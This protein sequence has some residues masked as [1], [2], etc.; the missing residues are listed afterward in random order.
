MK[1]NN[2]N[3]NTVL[4]IGQ[5]VKVP[6]YHV[7]VKATPGSQY[8]ELLDWWTEAQFVLKYDLPFTVTD[9][10]TG[11]SFQAVRSFG[12][13]HADCE[14]LTT[15]DT[16]AITNLWN[17]YHSSYWTARP[18]II[19][20]NGRKLA[21]S[22]TAAFHAGIDNAPNG[23]YVNNRSGGYG[24]GQNFDAIKGNGA[25]G[26]FDIHFLNS[27]THATGTINQN[28]QKAIRVAAGK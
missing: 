16:K 19:S 15:S 20:I 17:Q 8:G 5:V 1:A 25:D 3:S 22:M 6:V 12:A 18:V 10:Y 21:A 7:P 2:F 26:H 24:N 23:A 9:F 27:T 4:S 28:H 11:V 14:P 13:N